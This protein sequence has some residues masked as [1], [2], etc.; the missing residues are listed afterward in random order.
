MLLASIGCFEW[1]ETHFSDDKK[2]KRVQ[3]F[4]TFVAHSIT[5]SSCSTTL[6]TLKRH[7][8][9]HLV[10]FRRRELPGEESDDAGARGGPLGTPSDG[11][12]PDSLNLPE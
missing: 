1:D 9:W 5:R 4:E 6:I 12:V 3:G 7:L 8:G 2:G 10:G 11:R